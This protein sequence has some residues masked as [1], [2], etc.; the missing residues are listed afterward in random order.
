MSFNQLDFDLE[1]QKPFSDAPPE[2]DEAVD[3]SSD[4]LLEINNYLVTLT[5]QI[6]SLSDQ[7]DNSV[8]DKIAVTIDQLTELFKRMKLLIVKMDGFDE[9]GSV[10]QFSRDKIKNELHKLLVEFQELQLKFTQLTKQMNSEARTALAEE[11]ASGVGGA[12]DLGAANQLVVERDVINNEEFD[13]QQSLIREREEEIRNI[14]TGITELNEIF[15][16]LGSI[17]TQQGTLVDNIESNIFS[18][19]DNTKIAA[20][21]LS[22]A[23]YYQRRSRSR[24]LCVLLILLAILAVVLLG[25]FIL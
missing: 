1:N 11:H 6:N 9:L 16:D 25:I 8:A 4:V 17:V 5:K 2:L 10:Q 19:V 7:K 21:E 18:V 23:A 12:E 3:E 13:Y 15:K 20:S 24:S 14:E 22:R